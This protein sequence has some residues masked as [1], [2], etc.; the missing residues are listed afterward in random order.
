MVLDNVSVLMAII[1]S[2]VALRIDWT[3]V[4]VVN[5]VLHEPGVICL[6]IQ[7]RYLTLVISMI[8]L[9]WKRP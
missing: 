1:S 7:V 2:C 5:C 6:D 4:V 3:S 8:D 9:A